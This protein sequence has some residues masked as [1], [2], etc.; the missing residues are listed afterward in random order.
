MSLD[1]LEPK[2]NWDPKPHERTYYRD[3]VTGDL[4]WMVRRNGIDHIRLDRPADNIE[5]P[6]DVTRFT[7]DR[8]PAKLTS[9]MVAQIAFAAHKQLCLLTGK[10][11]ES[12]KDWARDMKVEDRAKWMKDGPKGELEERL[13]V[14]VR[15][16][17]GKFAR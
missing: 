11:A 16:A 17:L 2:R 1:E 9:A 13:F 12:K 3:A 14:A 8:E 7:M 6:Y 5:Q 15:E 4:G 10:F